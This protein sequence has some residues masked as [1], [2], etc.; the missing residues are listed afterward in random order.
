MLLN[1]QT[2][3]ERMEIRRALFFLSVVLIFSPNPCDG[4]I[5]RQSTYYVSNSGSDDDPGT[6]EMPWR[7]LVNISNFDFAPGDTVFFARGSRFTGGFII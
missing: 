4:A 5:N 3:R 7:T 1:Q 6:R 2:E